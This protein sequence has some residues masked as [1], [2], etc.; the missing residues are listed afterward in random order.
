MKSSFNILYT[1]SK[2][3]LFLG[4]LLA[5]QAATSQNTAADLQRA[6]ESHYR[7]LVASCDG[8]NYI[9]YEGILYEIRNARV[10]TEHHELSEADRLNGFAWKGQA[11]LR[12]AQNGAFRNWI[13]QTRSWNDWRAGQGCPPGH[14]L[15]FQKRNGQVTYSSN[16]GDRQGNPRWLL[17]PLTCSEVTGTISPPPQANQ[18]ESSPSGVMTV[19]EAQSLVQFYFRNTLKCNPREISAR[20][21]EPDPKEPNVFYIH[22]YSN[23]HLQGFPVREVVIRATR[24]NQPG[25][26]KWQMEAI[27]SDKDGESTNPKYYQWRSYVPT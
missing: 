22:G 5:S 3:F 7:T 6:A 27:P 15:Y 21:T 13:P 23:C 20:V 26:M 18:A 8:A 9:R 17:A 16:L 19:G 10:L 2:T 4:L 14:G 12:Y 24:R 1:R 25:E 11:C